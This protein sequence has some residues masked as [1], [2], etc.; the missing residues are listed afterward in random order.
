[1]ETVVNS[2]IKKE[3][4]TL[5][6]EV[7]RVYASTYQKEGTE[8]AEL[9][10]EVVTKSFYPTKS[11]SNDM[12]DNV[13]DVKDFGFEEKEYTNTEKRVAWIDVPAGTTAE[14]VAAK[15]AAHPNAGLYK[16]LANK[17]I[18]TENQKY[19][20]NNADIAATYDSFADSQVVRYP[21]TSDNVSLRGKLVLDANGKPQYRQVFFK[22]DSP[23][24]QDLRTSDEEFYA[25]EAIKAE[26]NNT[27][28]TVPTQTL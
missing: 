24:D 26:L 17:P 13:F 6:L 11:I 23:V 22:I 8:T 16:I 4:T 12:Q 28:H 27:V 2:R 18:L 5:A 19:A 7:S 9:R 10:Q 21:E 14:Q 25:S 1:M 3:S 15:L 20:V